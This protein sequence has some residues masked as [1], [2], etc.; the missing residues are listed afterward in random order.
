[1]LTRWDR[2]LSLFLGPKWTV[3]RAQ[4]RSAQRQYEAASRG[5][6]TKGWSRKTGD[7]NAVIRRALVDLRVHARD[8]VENNAWAKHGRRI[9]ANNV[10][11]TGIVPKALGPDSKKVAAL[12][13]AWANKTHCDAA[14]RLTFYGLQSL[15]LKT[16]V[17]DGEVL[18]RR[19]VRSLES[20]MPIPIQLEVLEADFLDESQDQPLAGGGKIVQGVEYDAS[21]RRVAYWLFEQHPGDEHAAGILSKRVPAD[22]VLHVFDLERAGQSR[23]VSWLAAAIVPLKDFDEYEDATLMRQKIAACF[24][25]FV[26]NDELGTPVGEED[27]NNEEIETLQPGMV[28]YLQP[29]RKISFGSPPPVTDDTFSVR[30]LRKIARAVGVTYEDLTGDYSQVNYSSARMSRLAHW[31]QISDLQ[32]HVLIPLFCDEVWGWVMG[33]AQAAGLLKTAPDAEWTAPAM[34]L[35]EPDKEARAAQLMVRNGQ[36]TFSGMVREMGEDPE[37][38]FEEY[39]TDVQKLKTLGIKLDTNVADVSQA[40]LSQASVQPAK[41]VEE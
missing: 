31:G 33:A 6:R 26:E 21:G 24:A 28:H 38:F 22:D 34:P 5:R 3:Q 40:G 4:W 25:A 29:G 20:G 9:L 1:M 15:I 36:K 13:K 16:L 8:L 41:K 27:E 37:T 30:T 39:A 32:W 17:T 14:R 18:I 19:R 12:W 11:G 10:V 7:A 35:I 2:F 23:G